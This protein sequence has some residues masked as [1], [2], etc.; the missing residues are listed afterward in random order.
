M[1]TLWTFGLARVWAAMFTG[2]RPEIYTDHAHRDAD[3]RRVRSELAA[4]RA[5]F[6][7]SDSRGAVDRFGRRQGRRL[8]PVDGPFGVRGPRNRLAG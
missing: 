2:P 7:K 8:Q 1:N 5:R 3:S 4:I 6:P